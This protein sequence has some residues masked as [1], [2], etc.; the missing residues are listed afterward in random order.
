[1]TEEKHDFQDAK[2]ACDDKQLKS[3]K[4][5]LPARKEKEIEIVQ[6]NNATEKD[7]MYAYGCVKQEENKTIQFNQNEHIVIEDY[8]IRISGD[9]CNKIFTDESGLIRHTSLMHKKSNQTNI[10]RQ[11]SRENAQE[12]TQY[13]T[14][15]LFSC[16]MC[17]KTFTNIS[18][19]KLH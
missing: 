6:E 3:H 13:E 9:F 18:K 8:E 11:S 15:K 12:E 14:I 4:I 5:I 7:D 19:L 2:L 1:M 17:S 10:N 16:N